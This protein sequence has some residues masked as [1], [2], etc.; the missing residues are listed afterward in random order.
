KQWN[1]IPILALFCRDWETR[2]EL[3]QMLL[4]SIDD[5]IC[6]PFEE[7][8]LLPRIRRLL[9]EHESYCLADTLLR[10]SVCELNLIGE[11]KVFLQ[12]LEKARLVASSDAAVTIIGE[13]GTGKELFAGAIHNLS[14]RRGKP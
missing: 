13:T 7:I 1:D 14:G 3:V 5:F 11:S 12:A 4:T 2:C 8:D 9:H 6:C 10:G